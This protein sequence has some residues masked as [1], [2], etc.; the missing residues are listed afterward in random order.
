VNYARKISLDESRGLKEWQLRWNHNQ[1][2]LWDDYRFRADVSMASQT[3][4]SNDLSTSA[5]R[6]VVSGQLRSSVYLSR[7]FDFMNASLDASRDE[8]VNAKDDDPATNNLLWT[9]ALPSLSFSFRQIT[10]APPLRTGHQGGLFGDLLRNTYFQQSYATSASW[11]RNE[12]DRANVQTASGNWSLNFRPPRIGIFSGAVGAS[13]RQSWTRTHVEGDRYVAGDT[14]GNPFEPYAETTERTSPSLSLNS[15]LATTLYGIFPLKIG[16]LRAIRHTLRMSAGYSWRP[17]LGS[18]QQRSQ[19]VSLS[20]GNRFDVKY[21]TTA[22][23]GDSARTAKLDGIIDWGLQAS[24]DPDADARRWSNIGSSL[25]LKPG[26]SRNLTLKLNNSIDPYDWLLLSTQLTYGLSIDGRLDTGAASEAE[27][28]TRRAELERLG[29]P[30]IG[31]ARDS[32]AA[33][34]DSL[35]DPFDEQY[36]DPFGRDVA[37]GVNEEPFNRRP[38]GAT[39]GSLARG[40]DPTE[41]GRFIPWRLGASFSYN[42]RRGSSVSSSRGNLTFAANPTRLWEFS[43]RA[44]FDLDAGTITRQEWSLNRDLH[45]WRLEFSRIVSTV[46]EQYAF[47]IYLQ[48]IPDVK[49]TRGQEDILGTATSLSGS[50]MP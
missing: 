39:G 25:T 35:R 18:K 16:R 20:V 11:R 33:L 37:G 47:R 2:Q 1:D 42:S 24:Y 50:L 9:M 14:T 31:A 17:Q 23:D 40:R 44:S 5:G 49:L 22:A 43:Y 10:L 15:S 41:G 7:S 45:C 34:A 29:V 8:R 30:E 28:A 13:A 19:A 38:G 27:E 36:D 32:L 4:S 46:D 12:L 26:R 48:S 3:L 6:D 21:A